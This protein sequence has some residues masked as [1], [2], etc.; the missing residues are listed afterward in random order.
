MAPNA[1]SKQHSY[2]TVQKICG[3]SRANRVHV[4]KQRG[5]SIMPPAPGGA[6]FTHL[7]IKTL[8]IQNKSNSKEIRNSILKQ[9]HKEL[10]IKIN[11][12]CVIVDVA[13]KV[14]RFS[15]SNNIWVL[16]AIMKRQ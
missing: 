9:H 7:H 3:I 14:V 4:S 12:G 15:T 16:I 1:F 6:S 10:T 13:S 2:V 11:T 5:W 8:I